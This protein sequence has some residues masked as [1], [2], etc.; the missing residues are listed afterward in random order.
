MLLQTELV[1]GLCLVRVRE[2]RLTDGRAIELRTEISEMLAAGANNLVLDFS[3][4]KFSG[5]HRSGGHCIDP[6]DGGG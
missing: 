6:K 3:N 2:D 1:D 5:Q 4:V